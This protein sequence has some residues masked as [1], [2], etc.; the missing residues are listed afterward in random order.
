VASE[1]KERKGENYRPC[2]N[3]ITYPLMLS[4]HPLNKVNPTKLIG[5]FYTTRNPVDQRPK[6]RRKKR[7]YKAIIKRK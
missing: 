5:S 6:N 3:K 7:K 2:R 4:C 1:G